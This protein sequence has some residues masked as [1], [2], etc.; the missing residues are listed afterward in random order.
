MVALDSP[1]N[2][3]NVTERFDI[4]KTSITTAS[5]RMIPL[6][7]AGRPQTDAEMSKMRSTACRKAMGTL[8]RITMTRPVAVRRAQVNQVR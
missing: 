3:Q 2:A 8:V 4:M 7:K 1:Q 6:V 5:P